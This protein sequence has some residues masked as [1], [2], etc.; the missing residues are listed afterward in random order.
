MIML[1]KTLLIILLIIIKITCAGAQAENPLVELGTQ[2]AQASQ[3]STKVKILI[4]IGDYYLYRDLDSTH[5]YYS[6]AITVV[7][8]SSSA[9]V[10]KYKPLSLRKICISYTTQRRIDEAWV[11]ANQAIKAYEEANLPVDASSMYILL[12]VLQSA[13]GNHGK[14]VDLLDSC[15]NLKRVLKTEI[16]LGEAHMNLCEIL[17]NTHKY[18]KALTHIDTA[19][20][21]FNQQGNQLSEYR[22]YII[23][24]NLYRATS[25]FDKSLDILL[26]VLDLYQTNPEIDDKRAEVNIL[27]NIAIIQTQLEQ[28]D[29]AVHYNKE[30]LKILESYNDKYTEANV[31]HN[32]SGFSLEQNQFEEAMNYIDKA[33]SLADSFGMADFVASCYSLKGKAFQGLNQLPQALEAHQKS[34]ELTSKENP[35][36][37]VSS[38]I[39]GTLYFDAYLQ[40]DPKEKENLFQAIKYFEFALAYPSE[41]YEQEIQ[42]DNLWQSYV[43]LEDW[44]MAGKVSEKLVTLR[45]SISGLKN[46]ETTRELEEKYQNKQKTLEIKNLNQ[47]KALQ[48]AK[49]RQQE[50][51]LYG[52]GIFLLIILCFL[53]FV[54]YLYRQK[55]LINKKL[56]AQNAIVEKQ[57]KEKELLLKEIHHRVKNNLQIISSLLELQSENVKDSNAIAAISEGQNRV[58]SIAMIH[59]KLYQNDNVATVNFKEYTEQL[60]NQILSLFNLSNVQK[61]INIPSDCEFD[62]DTAIPLG[63]ILNELF[64]NSCKYAFE[65]N[66]ENKISFDLSSDKKGNFQLSVKDNGAGLPENFDIWEAESLGLRLICRLS[67]QLYGDVEYDNNQGAHFKIEFMDTD[68]RKEM[69]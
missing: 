34:L 26:E 40:Q 30:V 28:P 36:Y 43:L 50:T 64:T 37:G 27:M 66:R 19:I 44:K 55:E 41:L 69:D 54:Y 32:L 39:L 60:L 13:K 42:Y 63:L 53:G 33:I 59:Q 14:A 8:R 9:E 52:G 57:N 65:A 51:L 47:Q 23:K 10:K 6:Q 5:H 67:Q 12:G 48:E 3:D 18:D 17:M 22:S 68:L 24:S 15:I 45:D 25:Q 16:K 11:Y 29:K 31:Y 2:L 1:Q 56:A 61:M 4:A 7:E 62:I 46:I 21:I 20:T 49:N 35:Q 38:R 58:R